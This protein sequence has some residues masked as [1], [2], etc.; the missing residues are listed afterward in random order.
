[1]HD[2]RG[3][4]LTILARS[5]DSLECQINSLRQRRGRLWSGTDAYSAKMDQTLPFLT[6]GSIFTF[7]LLRSSVPHGSYRRL[8]H[9]LTPSHRG[10]IEIGK[11]PA[12]DHKFKTPDR[13]LLRM[14]RLHE[15]LG[16]VKE[17]DIDRVCQSPF[18]KGS[19]LAFGLSYHAGHQAYGHSRWL[20]NIVV[21]GLLPL[22]RIL[23]F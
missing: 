10:G 15:Q 7:V 3:R 6:D 14:A 20:T 19:V 9:A 8:Q 12:L 16:W 1:M 4:Q 23:R 22:V 17:S 13:V 2:T 11:N 21:Q 5:K 18:L